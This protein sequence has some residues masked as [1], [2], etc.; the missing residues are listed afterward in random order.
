MEPLEPLP[1]AHSA[2]ARLGS[3]RRAV[4]DDVPTTHLRCGDDLRQGLAAAGFCGRFTVYADPYCQGP[5]PREG[6][7]QETRAR[8][9]SAAY[10]L[11]LDET[12]RR[13]IIEQHTLATLKASPRVVLWFEHDSYDQLILA[14]VLAWLAEFGCPAVLELICIDRFPGIERFVGLG[15]LTPAQLRDLWPARQAVKTDLLVLAARVWAALREPNPSELAAIASDGTPELPMMAN[16][17]RRHLA[18]L[19]GTSDGLSL[20][21]R[22]TLRLLEQR[23]RTGAALF[24]AL[25]ERADPLPF[26]GDLMYW[27]VLAGLLGVEHPAIQCPQSDRE[28]P[29][30]SRRLLLTDLG[31]AV[32]A[33]AADWLAQGPAERWVGGVKV[34]TRG[35]TWRWDEASGTLANC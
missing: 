6:D 1:A 25:H 21:E 9:L 7:L 15:Q 8:F 35:A 26:L 2:N 30:P 27:A 28:V 11:D 22:L 33:G 3:D 5:V 29:W 31:R 10:R 16:A 12:R 34:G 19:P 13:L 14:R 18:E 24:R 4:D 17:L 20:T 32:L 23:P